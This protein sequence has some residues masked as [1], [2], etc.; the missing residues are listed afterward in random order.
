MKAFGKLFS[1]LFVSR[2]STDAED[3]PDLVPLV[4]ED[5]KKELDV[6]VEARKLA[7]AGLPEADATTLSFP[8]RKIIQRLEAVRANYNKWALTR[9]NTIH[10]QLNSFD[11][12]LLVNRAKQYGDEYKRLANKEISDAEV[13]LGRRR[14]AAIRQQDELDSFCKDNK[15]NREAYYPKPLAKLAM[16]LVGLALVAGEGFLNA[17][18]FAQGMDSGLVGGFTQAIILAAV[19][20]LIPVLL[21]CFLIPNVNHIHSGRRLI[22][23]FGFFLVFLFMGYMALGIGHYREA[24]ILAVDEQINATALALDS[25]RATP[26]GLTDLSSWLLCLISIVFAFIGLLEGYKLDDPYPGYGRCHRKAHAVITE[27]HNLVEQLR[28]E[29]TGLKEMLLESLEH[30][31]ERAKVCVLEFGTLVEDKASCEHRLKLNISKAENMLHALINAFRDEN[32]IHRSGVPRPAYFD[33][34]PAL[35]QIELP[36]FDTTSELAK[37]KNQESLLNE[38]LSDV[39]RVRGAIQS[40]YDNR[41][42]QLKAIHQQI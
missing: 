35:Q 13:E 33:S 10:E 12:N 36:I 34:M 6:E 23:Y 25:L 32:K 29:I 17:F 3:H 9:V 18:F 20:F 37:H 2:K 26:L 42:D 22:G 31:V 7:R 39:E 16:L 15:L 11:I 14:N 19:N 4:F 28:G 8:E 24:M 21:G 27:Y 1:W 5:L 38:L 30:D 41:F 40:A